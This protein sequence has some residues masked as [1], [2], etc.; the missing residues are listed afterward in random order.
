MILNRGTSAN[1]LATAQAEDVGKQTVN[2]STK[3]ETKRKHKSSK[4]RP[5]AA[6]G[7]LNEMQQGN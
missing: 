6:S 1:K 7:A 5:A 2:K 4:I 3:W